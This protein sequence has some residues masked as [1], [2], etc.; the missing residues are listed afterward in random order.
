MSESVSI[1]EFD[2]AILDALSDDGRMPVSAIA[3]RASLSATPVSRRLKRLEEDGVIRGY[4]PILDMRKLGFELEAYLLVN[5]D[6]HNDTNIER[7][8]K[9]IIDNA[10]VISCRAV[11]GDMDYLIHVIARDMEDLSQIT[12]KTLV[13]IPG[14]RDVKSILVLETVKQVRTPPVG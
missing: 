9:A 8:E 13:R 1:D 12:L 2:R 11:T 14:V 3:E 10:Q 5:L 4:A 6:A 7:F